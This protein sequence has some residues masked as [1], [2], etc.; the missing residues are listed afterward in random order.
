MKPEEKRLA[1]VCGLYCGECNI[2]LAAHGE[3]ERQQNIAEKISETTGREVK[4]EE[5]KC[6]G[7]WGPIETHWSPDCK[8]RNCAVEKGFRFCFQCE[9]YPCGKLVMFKDKHYPYVL[10]NLNRIKQ[11]GVEAWL[12][13]QEA[14]KHKK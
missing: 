14:K 5:I 8:L 7:C 12:K 2:Y 1:A 3:T 10:D 11:I 4:P 9:E 13:E 6:E